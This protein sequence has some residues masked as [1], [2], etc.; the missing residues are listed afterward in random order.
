MCETVEIINISQQSKLSEE[1]LYKI[2]SSVSL[3]VTSTSFTPIIKDFT[4][5]RGDEKEVIHEKEAIL[6]QQMSSEAPRQLLEA[7]EE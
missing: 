2:G 3:I 6:I 1:Y 5:D 4:R 7:S